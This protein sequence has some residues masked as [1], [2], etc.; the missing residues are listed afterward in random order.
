[1]SPIGRK[2]NEILVGAFNALNEYY[3][4]EK[5]FQLLAA[6]G[7]DFVLM[8]YLHDEKSDY[9]LSMLEKHGIKAF[10]YDSKL[11]SSDPATLTDE[12]VLSLSE[13]YRHSPSFLG[14]G[15]IDEPADEIFP[16]LGAEVKA[17]RHAIP[18]ALFHINLLPWYAFNDT[19]VFRKH[20][21]NFADTVEIN[22]ISTDDYPLWL[23]KDGS[24]TTNDCYYT[25]LN[26]SAQMA[27]DYGRE[28]WLYID[29]FSR[30]SERGFRVHTRED[31]FF[32]AY[33][34]LTFG[35]CKILYFVFDITGYHG[36]PKE[37]EGAPYGMRDYARGVT[38][39]Y[40]YGK[41]LADSL[42]A[43]SDVYSRYSWK[44]T[45]AVLCNGKNEKFLEELPVYTENRI[46][47]EQTNT[48]LAIGSFDETDADGSAFMVMNASEI[49][50]N[51]TANVVFRVP[52]AET[53]T[54]HIGATSVRLMPDSE[55]LYRMA[56]A[57]GM[58][59]FL[60]ITK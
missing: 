43:L 24:L 12:M 8:S 3:T 50:E 22:H 29:T 56:I 28:H 53:I 21:K 38:E 1:M 18:D 17:I 14:F 9:N 6:S 5:D 19:E 37:T 41:D 46:V 2:K 23:Q 59:N 32:Q 7:V 44:H 25:G 33:S 34:G 16:R 13:P 48:G 49:S 51:I 35:A 30:V 55:G 45:E 11:N 31:L 58:A 47:I 40:G 4:E 15:I 20:L 36:V 57:P 10:F 26:T 52:G 42:H 54:A 60:T 27:R 39:L